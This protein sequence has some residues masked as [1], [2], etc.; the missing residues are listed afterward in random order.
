ML[1]ES[2]YLPRT[3]SV[4]LPTKYDHIFFFFSFKSH[5]NCLR[6][7]EFIVNNRLQAS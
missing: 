6:G 5:N 3:L 7:W 4:K 2:V 1:S